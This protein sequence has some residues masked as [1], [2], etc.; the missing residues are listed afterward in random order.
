[1]AILKVLISYCFDNCDPELPN[2]EGFFPKYRPLR[3]DDTLRHAE[4]ETELMYADALC[5]TAQIIRNPTIP[6]DQA[7]SVHDEYIGLPYRRGNPSLDDIPIRLPALSNVEKE[8][9]NLSSHIES[10]DV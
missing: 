8:M 9:A 5:G 6:S 7:T 2:H 4:W 1:M 10:E 3:K